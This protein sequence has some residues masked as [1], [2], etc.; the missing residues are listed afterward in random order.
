ME[1]TEHKKELADRVAR[2]LMETLD[3]RNTGLERAFARLFDSIQNKTLETLES[4]LL[5][6]PPVEKTDA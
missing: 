3:Y 4:L 5:A 1:I 6:V 2:T